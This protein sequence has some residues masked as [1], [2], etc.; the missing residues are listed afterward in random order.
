MGKGG[1]A[2]HDPKQRS[3]EQPLFAEPAGFAPLPETDS[4]ELDYRIRIYEATFAG[5]DVCDPHDSTWWLWWAPAIGPTPVVVVSLLHHLAV[6]DRPVSAASG[7]AA[8]GLTPELFVQALIVAGHHRL[9]FLR[10]REI[11]LTSVIPRPPTF[12]EKPE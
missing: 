4:T 10:G 8:V 5:R 2:G 6:A 1:P 7:A 3:Y 9:M 12:K 11:G